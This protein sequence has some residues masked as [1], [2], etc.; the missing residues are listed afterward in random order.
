MRPSSERCCSAEGPHDGA[1]TL[2]GVVVSYLVED[3]LLVPAMAAR[4]AVV[5]R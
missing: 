1:R 5:V 2:K 4:P 3:L